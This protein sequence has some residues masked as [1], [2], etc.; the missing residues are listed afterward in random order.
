ME[1]PTRMYGGAIFAVVRECQPP[2]MTVEAEH[3]P[4]IGEALDALFSEFSNE[5]KK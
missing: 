2:G 5:S 1:C 3:S 4:H